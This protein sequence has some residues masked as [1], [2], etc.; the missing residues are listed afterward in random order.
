[1]SL[2]HLG[3]HHPAVHAA[4]DP[5]H[6][7]QIMAGTG[8]TQTYA[9]LAG[10]SA[11]GARLLVASGLERGDHVALLMENHPAFLTICWSAMRAGLYCTP[12]STWLGIDEASAVVVDAGAE[13]LITTPAQA[14]VAEALV[15]MVPQ[16]ASGFSVGGPIDGF[17]S[18]ESAAADHR[19]DALGEEPEGSMMLYSSGT[20]SRPKGVRRPLSGGPAGTANPLAPFLP[21]VGLDP[22]TVY[23]SPAPLYHGAPVGWSLGTQRMGGTVVVMEHFD[24]EAALSAIERY[25]VTH[26]QLVPT[27]LVRLMKLPRRV[28]DAYDLSSLRHVVHAGAPCPPEVKDG[29]IEWLGPIVDEYYSGTEGNGITFI[30]SPEWLVHRGSVGRPILGRIHI[31]DEEGLEQPAG[32]EGI[33]WFSSGGTF[34]YHGDAGATAARTDRRGWTTLDDVGYVDEDGYLYLTDRRAHMIVT[35]GVNVSPREVED[36]LVVHPSVADV[37][38]IGVPDDE[39]GESVLALVVPAD[40]APAH[41]LEQQLIDH[42]RARLARYKCPRSVELVSDLPRLPTGKL[43]KRLLRDGRWAGRTSRVI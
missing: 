27:M 16:L 39:F 40:D 36:A 10:E 24:P 35:G 19:R 31:T 42:C 43:A 9:D 25:R 2:G 34:E 14:E 29:V 15:R 22:D 11:Q 8:Q 13:A 33:V 30:T 38:V 26:V 4:R 37:A 18:W 3:P 41:G 5:D 1:M 32:E 12:V 7:A 6:A 28:R 23:L 20:T 21:H 17:T